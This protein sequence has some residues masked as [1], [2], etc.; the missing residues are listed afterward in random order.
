MIELTCGCLPDEAFPVGVGKINAKP[1]LD[2]C[3]GQRAKA[4]GKLGSPI[5]KRFKK[6][7]PKLPI[8]TA[9]G[10][11]PIYDIEIDPL[12]IAICSGT[13]GYGYGYGNQES[14]E[15]KDGQIKNEFL[16]FIVN[17]GSA[18]IE[19]R[20]GVDPTYHDDALG[21]EKLWMFPDSAERNAEKEFDLSYF[22]ASLDLPLE[23][24]TPKVIDSKL[25]ADGKVYAFAYLNPLGNDEIGVGET[26][27]QSCDEVSSKPDWA[28]SQDGS[29]ANQPVTPQVYIAIFRLTYVDG[30]EK[31]QIS[32]KIPTGF[33]DF[34]DG[35]NKIISGGLAISKDGLTVAVSNQEEDSIFENNG[36]IKIFR[37]NSVTDN[38]IRIDENGYDSTLSKVDNPKTY[39]RNYIGKFRSPELF[40]TKREDKELA[41]IGKPLFNITE[42]VEIA[43]ETGEEYEEI[44]CTNTELFSNTINADLGVYVARD[45]RREDSYILVTKDDEEDLGTLDTGALYPEAESKRFDGMK[46]PRSVYFLNFINDK[47][48]LRSEIDSKSKY[49]QKRTVTSNNKP[50]VLENAVFYRYE[51][52]DYALTDNGVSIIQVQDIPDQDYYLDKMAD[53]PTVSLIDQGK[54]V[55]AGSIQQKTYDAETNTMVDAEISDAKQL[56]SNSSSYVA[57]KENN[58]AVP[59]GSVGDGGASPYLWTNNT[60]VTE[61]A[62]NLSNIRTI[63]ST[64]RA[65]AAIKNDGSVVSW[66]DTEFGANNE[67]NRF[68]S[69]ESVASLH[70]RLNYFSAITTEGKVSTWG[71]I[72]RIMENTDF[73]SLKQD[74]VLNKDFINIDPSQPD[75]EDTNHRYLYLYDQDVA[76]YLNLIKDQDPNVTVSDKLKKFT[77]I[78]SNPYASVALREDGVAVAW[79]DT[80]H[81]ARPYRDVYE[82]QDDDNQTEV[83]MSR[84]EAIRNEENKNKIQADQ[85]PAFL[86][87]GSIIRIVLFNSLHPDLSIVENVWKIVESSSGLLTLEGLDGSIPDF[88]LDGINEGFSTKINSVLYVNLG[89]D[90]Q[91]NDVLS[92]INKVELNNIDSVVSNYY[93]FAAVKKDGTAI[94]W[95][96]KGYGGDHPDF[97][98]AEGET[99][100]SI[101]STVFAF[102]ALTSTGR[103]VAWGKQSHGG[104]IT[105]GTESSHGDTSL[106]DAENPVTEIYSARVGFMAVRKDKSVVVWGNDSLRYGVRQVGPLARGLYGKRDNYGLGF[107]IDMDEDG[108][109][110]LTGNKRKSF[111]NNSFT[112]SVRLYR[113]FPK[114][115]AYQLMGVKGTLFGSV[116]RNDG[117]VSFGRT[118]KINRDASKI[119]THGLSEETVVLPDGTVENQTKDSIFQHHVHTSIYENAVE[120]GED[121]N[122]LYIRGG[123]SKKNPGGTRIYNDTFLSQST[124]IILPDGHNPDLP[125]INGD[126]GLKINNYFSIDASGFNIAIATPS[127]GEFL[128][129]NTNNGE[130]NIYSAKRDDF[131]QPIIKGWDHQKR[132]TLTPYIE[133]DNLAEVSGVSD[134]W[135]YSNL[136]G[137]NL[138][139]SYE[140]N[141]L[142]VSS[143]DSINI[144]EYKETA[145]ETSDWT[146]VSKF[147]QYDEPTIPTF[148]NSSQTFKSPTRYLAAHMDSGGSYVSTTFISTEANENDHYS[149]SVYSI[150]YD[151]PFSRLD[152][153]NLSQSYLSHFSSTIQ[154]SGEYSQYLLTKDTSLFNENGTPKAYGK[155]QSIAIGDR[156]TTSTMTFAFWSDVSERSKADK[157]IRWGRYNVN[158]LCE[159]TNAGRDVQIQFS[160]TNSGYTKK[161]K[162][163]SIQTPQFEELFHFIVTYN[164]DSEYI[165][166]FIAGESYEKETLPSFLSDFSISTEKSYV[167][168]FSLNTAQKEQILDDVRVFSRVLSRN[169]IFKLANHRKIAYRTDTYYYDVNYAR[170]NKFNLEFV[171]S[172][173]LDIPIPQFC[174]T[175]NYVDDCGRIL[176]TECDLDAEVKFC[177]FTGRPRV[178]YVKTFGGAERPRNLTDISLSGVQRFLDNTT[179]TVREDQQSNFDVFDPDWGDEF[180]F[181]VGAN[182]TS[183][184]RRTEQFISGVSVFERCHASMDLS[185][186]PRINGVGEIISRKMNSDFGVRQVLSKEGEITSRWLDK[187]HGDFVDWNATDIL[188]PARDSG[189]NVFVTQDGLKTEL[190]KSID[191]GVFIGGDYSSAQGPISDDAV[192]YIQASAVNTEFEGTFGFYL[193]DAIT[194][195]YETRLRMRLSGPVKNFESEISPKF[196]FSNIALKNASGETVVK[197]EDF[198]F[199]GDS[200]QYEE[201]PGYTTYSLAPTF[202]SSRKYQ[203]QDGYPNIDSPSG[204]IIT[205]DVRSEDRG[206]PYKPSAFD[207]GWAMDN[208]FGV[209]DPEFSDFYSVSGYNPTLRISAIEVYNSGRLIPFREQ[210]VGCYMLGQETGKRFERIIKPKQ[211]LFNTFDTN[212]H[213]ALSGISNPSGW[214]WEDNSYTYTNEDCDGAE[215]LLQIINND[216]SGSWITSNHVYN[217]S[218]KL[219]LKFGLDPDDDYYLFDPGQFATA[220]GSMFSRWFDPIQKIY[221]KEEKEVEV[222]DSFFEFDSIVLRVLANKN[223]DARDYSLDI[224][225]YSDDCIMNSTPKVGG[226]LQNVSGEFVYNYDSSS[227]DEFYPQGTIPH[228]SGFSDV[229]DLGLSSEAI[230][231]KNQYF[232]SFKTNNDGGDHY[233]LSNYPVVSGTDFR[234]YEV[235]LK[236]YDDDVE[237]GRSRNYKL[238]SLLE[239]LYLDIYALPSGANI[240]G[241]ELAVR[242]KPCAGLELNTL[243]GVNRSI[244]DGRS[245]GSFYPVSMQS[246]DQIVNAG[247]GY[248]PLSLIENI[249]HAYTTP[250]TIKTNYAR[251]WRGLDGISLNPFD[252]RQFDYSFDKGRRLKRPLLGAW[253]DFSDVD[254][255]FPSTVTLNSNHALENKS[256]ILT[257]AGVNVSP[258]LYE[259]I[260]S[261]FRNQDMFTT[262]APGYSSNYRT[263]DWTALSNGSN[264]YTNDPLYGR[265]SDAYDRVVRFGNKTTATISDVNPASGAAF[266]FRFIPDVNVSGEGQDNFYD[267]STI[268]SLTQLELVNQTGVFIGYS[269]GYLFASGENISGDTASVI[270]TIPFSGYQYP[271]SVLVTYSEHLDNKLRLYT[272]HEGSGN[273]QHLRDTSTAIEL[274]NHDETFRVGFGGDSMSGLPML[275]AE[276]G[277]SHAVRTESDLI[278]VDVSGANIVNQNAVLNHKQ[279]TADQFFSN[280][281]QKFF[282]PN[283]SHEN[284]STMLWSYVDE[285]TSVSPSAEWYL[286][287]FRGCD[288]NWQ[289]DSINNQKLGKRSYTTE[290]DDHLTFYLSHDGTSYYANIDNDLPSTL[291]SGL[292]YHSQVEND[293]LRFY[294]SD[295]AHNFH[296]IKKR[297]S[298]NLPAGYDFA[299]SALVVDLIYEHHSSGDLVWDCKDE[300]GPKL[301][302]S[303]YTKNQEPYYQT[304]EPNWGLINRHYHYVNPSSCLEKFESKFTYDDY[305]DES[306]SWAVFP[307]ERRLSESTEKYFS[308]DVD[309]MFL[310]IDISYPSGS[311]FNSELDIHAIHVRAEDAFV[312]PVEDSGVL[313]MIASGA[314]IENNALDFYTFGVLGYSSGVPSGLMM[315]TDGHVPVEDSGILKIIMSGFN[316]S[317]SSLGLVTVNKRRHDSGGDD[318]GDDYWQGGDYEQF[319]VG[320][321]VKGLQ[322]LISGQT[323]PTIY[324]D[325]GSLKMLTEGIGMDSGQMPLFIYNDQFGLQSISQLNLSMFAA[326]SG[327]SGVRSELSLSLYNDAES[328]SQFGTLNSSFNLSTSGESRFQTLVN[329]FASM[330]LFTF[331]PAELPASA[332]MPLFLDATPEPIEKSGT[333]EMMVRNNGVTNYLPNIPGELNFNW[334]GESY[335]EGIDLEDEPYASLPANDEIRGVDLFGYGNCDSD[336]EDKAFDE[337]VISDGIVWRDRVCN[338]GGIFRATN[339][340]TNLDAGYEDEYYGIR[341]YAGLKGSR[342]YFVSMTI[343]T[344]D[345]TPISIPRE[346]EE[347]EYGI[348]GPGTVGDQDQQ[349][350]NFSGIK[351]IG[352]YPYLSGDYSITSEF[353]VE[354]GRQN[355]DRYGFSSSCHGDLIAVG[356]PYHKILD[357]GNQL[358]DDAGAVFLYRRNEEQ[359]GRKADWY[360]EE[361]LLMPEGTRRDYIQREYGALVTYPPNLTIG[362]KKWAIGQEGREFGYSIDVGASGEK[363]VVVVGAPGAKWTRTFPEVTVSGIPVLMTIFTDKFTYNKDK[364]LQIRST[365]SKY[366]LLYKYFSKPWGEDPDIWHPQLDIHLLICQVYNSDNIDDLPNVPDNRQN[367]GAAPYWFNHVYINNLKDAQREDDDLLTEGFNKVVGKF[368]QIF[369]HNDNIYSGI[370][371]IFGV[372]GD[373]TFST[374]NKQ[375]FLGILDKFVD[376]YEDY[377]YASGVEDMSQSTYTPSIGYVEKI[378]DDAFVWNEATVNLMNKTLSSGNLIKTGNL[379]FI[380]EGIGQEFARDDVGEF[381]LPPESGGRAFVFEKEF[382]EWNLVQEFISPFEEIES[383]DDSYDENL[384]FDQ[385][386]PVDRYGHAVGISENCE[387]IS[388]GSPFSAEACQIFERNDDAN[389]DM[390]KVL[391][392]WLVETN[393]PY[394]NP[395]QDSI[396]RF[397]ELISGSGTIAT[398]TQVYK[399]LSKKNKFLL[400]KN[401]NIKLYDKIFK[402]HYT[403]IA[404]T[405]SFGIITNEFAGTSR[406][407][408]STSVSED[409]K[410]VVFGA[411]TDSFNE[412]DDKNV[413]YG[414]V[415]GVNYPEN[416][417]WASYTNAGAVRVFESRSYHTHNKAVEFYKFGNLDRSFNKQNLVNQGDT[418]AYEK[419]GSYFAVDNIPFERT[420]FDEIEIP[421][422]AG[423]AFIITPE[424]DA[425]SDEIM[426]NIKS[427]LSL[428]DRTLVLVGNDPQWKQGGIYSKSNEIINKILKKLGCRM[429]ITSA[430]N[431]VESLEA[432]VNTSG[433]QNDKFNVTLAHLPQYMHESDA[434][435]ENMYASGVGDI[436]I[437]LSDL[438]LEDLK[439][440]SPCDPD[441]PELDRCIPPIEHMGDLRSEWFSECADKIEFYTNWAFHFD[442]ANPGQSCKFY[443]Q[444]VKPLVVKPDEEITPILTAAEYIPQ[445]DKI[446]PAQSGE[447]EECTT[448]LSGIIRKENTIG[449]TTYEFAENHI[450]ELIF[451]IKDSGNQAVGLYTSINRD[452][453][454]NPEKENGR[455]ALLQGVGTDYSGSSNRQKV[456]VSD[457]SP[458]VTEEKFEEEE[459]SKLY[460][461]ASQLPENSWSMGLRFGDQYDPRNEDQNIAFYNNLVMID[462]EN[463]ARIS[464]LGGWTGRTSFE[465]AFADSVIKTGLENYNHIVDTN[466]IYKEDSIIPESVSVIWIA[467]PT[468]AIPENYVAPIKN[469]IKL[470]NKKVIVTYNRD[471]QIAT[472]V[473]LTLERLG[474]ETRPFFL[475]NQ[476]KYFIQDSRVLQDSAL[477]SCC[478]IDS[479]LSDKL[480]IINKE[481]DVIKG[482]SRGYKWFG[483]DPNNTKS[484]E[485]DK[486]SAIPNTANPQSLDDDGTDP[487]GDGYNGYAYIP[488]QISGSRTTKVV[489]MN[490]PIHDLVWSNPDTFWKID[491]DATISLPVTPESGYRLFVDWISETDNEIYDI[492]FQVDSEDVRFSADPEGDEFSEDS[493]KQLGK[494]TKFISK[495][496]SV[497]FRVKSGVEN[498]RVKLDTKKWRAIKDEDVKGDRPYTPRILQVR[499]YPL[500]IIETYNETTTFKDEK[501]YITKCSGVPWYIPERRITFPPIFRPVSTNHVKYCNPDAELCSEYDPTLDVEDGPVI[502]ADELEHFSDFSTGSKRSRVV[503]VTDSSM[504][505]G[506]NEHYRY[507]IT[508]PNVRFIRSLYPQRPSESFFYSEDDQYISKKGTKFEFTQKLRAPEKGSPSKYFASSGNQYLVEKFGLNGVAG[509]LENYTDQ[510][511]NF[512]LGDVFR[513]FTP[514]EPVKIEQEIERFGGEVVPVY[515]TYPRFSGNF[516]DPEVGEVNHWVDSNINGGVSKYMERT[517]RDYLDYEVLSSG[518][519]G[520]LFGFSVDLY[521]GK[522]VIGTPFNAYHSEQAISW[523]GIYDAYTAGNVGSGLNLS[524]RGGAGAAFYFERTGRGENAIKEFLPWEYKQKIKPVDSLNVGIDDATASD[525]TTLKGSH[526]FS[527]EFADAFAWVPDLFGW[528]VS[529]ESDFIAVGAPAHDYETLHNHIYSGQ[530]AFLRKEFSY[531]FDIPT[532]E[533]YDLGDA[534]VRGQYP[535][536]GEMILNNGAV[537]TFRHDFDNY[538]DRN[539]VWNF[540]EKIVAQGHNDRLAGSPP[541][542]GAENDMFGYSVCLQQAKRSDSDYVMIVGAPY[543]MHPTSGNHISIEISGAG[544]AYTYDAMLRHQPNVVPTQGS[545]IIPTV[546]GDTVGPNR[547]GSVSGKFYQNVEGPEITYRISGVISATP[548][549]SIFLEVS[550]YDPADRGFTSQRPF[551]ESIYGEYLS[552][553]EVDQNIFMLTAGKAPEAS[554]V[555]PLFVYNNDEEIVSSSMYA[556]MY[557]GEPIVIDNSFG[558]VTSGIGNI[559]KS[560][561]FRTRGK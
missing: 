232:D 129:N 200:D 493:P 267:Q 34:S 157:I 424:L 508:S 509:N 498:I 28:V 310:Q 375:S 12:N 136:F 300:V 410:T 415:T 103:V 254:D 171:E 402:Y 101:S 66:G 501:V 306:E 84:P 516:Y 122:K 522:L 269:G 344:G 252:I 140:G 468:E 425:A 514:R 177:F 70:P 35:A 548:Q 476:A 462:C 120:L 166:L 488:I 291:N 370:P 270:D 340:Y 153:D 142:L 24:Q 464:Q 16:D 64:Q 30:K 82:F 80:M 125:Y 328:F 456:K 208:D 499:G 461:I 89:L 52:L 399:E 53:D 259:N 525:L 314:F 439:V 330:P 91:E 39:Q 510:E 551:I 426:D 496:H 528:S 320:N 466:V 191:E 229:D 244:Q 199:V 361:K 155:N 289:Y 95:G 411:P 349:T 248:Q 108:E 3:N 201:D 539:K 347:W 485:V 553:T 65:H 414:G 154:K 25:S 90:R 7:L 495:S 11:G 5:R 72:N 62:V 237:L 542:S 446:I 260:G 40:F 14:C 368:K 212:I 304:D 559:Q 32:N 396:D 545:Y 322:M 507:D 97:A 227:L 152:Y 316:V 221:N 460:L 511:D 98:L 167:G 492:N 469:W 110:I 165:E 467:S 437:D 286:G 451:N 258:E 100:V 164:R 506:F 292:A 345:T 194:S 174:N 189:N 250:S 216:S 172:T 450:N 362:A 336:S 71:N 233:A 242:H 371:P 205:F 448:T 278:G 419:L 266:F 131:I 301:I 459:T 104:D 403:D 239:K 550:G 343:K 31:W 79:G 379:K 27:P 503:L 192:T 273:F 544:S 313:K 115:A 519:N 276:F 263:A 290:R 470:G 176:D 401:K 186:R 262:L 505:Q 307:K 146:Q 196:Y 85:V 445:A 541:V 161:F 302:V 479:E 491:G 377:S 356:A 228:T 530:A 271:L 94:S 203:W 9:V 490:D 170:G 179:P 217:D 280:I 222:Q 168:G 487:E 181:V 381:Q 143:R 405:G 193:T 264:D 247:S 359:A 218:G 58:V 26:P 180:M 219:I 215:Q 139:L 395:L 204:Y 230:S 317:N 241:I 319:I 515:G 430:R 471:Q 158:I 309:D 56:F 385:R 117:R 400:R 159:P 312:K 338:E 346:W 150:D 418:N 449:T 183:P 185:P 10:E 37:Y 112:G 465:D 297:V 88:N 524:G 329:S 341:K 54:V 393:D 383:N 279:I 128:S 512:V 352:D 245:E 534:D 409:G 226:F 357:S 537:Y 234:W 133:E 397:N 173:Y 220:F 160:D 151:S 55:T 453:F 435:R 162:K 489:T 114:T 198:N 318:D 138:S 416:N 353:Q 366:D 486:L 102:A 182:H 246:N 1:N 433:I 2:M 305:C 130:V 367:R 447:E 431:R 206:E 358:I 46:R 285:N 111:F 145:Y 277:F 19:Y 386:N 455:D 382:G 59:Y 195:P 374:N 118:V 552:G 454:V 387:I 50:T 517:G 443:P 137:E 261:R 288:F 294:L 77:S 293:F 427:W 33:F 520:D 76:A 560:L 311:A 432:G 373:D 283:E 538:Q 175:I 8:K 296:S 378:F 134:N 295:T 529:V 331:A 355:G 360:L 323:P 554:A 224:V 124:Q 23:R 113:R 106:S 284:D 372:F 207:F 531:E 558:F 497:D 303:L 253:I 363:E 543:H 480:Q 105:F 342:P 255:G 15:F 412:F 299:D 202:N 188:Y 549:G 60:K 413:W 533:F 282:D 494:T 482:C 149:H 210:F 391:Y 404:Y 184:A 197:Y 83:D 332:S 178:T 502:V 45:Q 532:H 398:A 18:E 392:D 63:S 556:Y 394:E 483:M 521:K 223:A 337:Q 144:Y 236:V 546:Y 74:N 388:V 390:Y 350:L 457:I 417:T 96:L 22:I 49:I 41:V 147:Y 354:S 442:T 315:Y 540:A 238:S 42:S 6:C 51:T 351:L 44:A 21:G 17:Y 484:T 73:E 473:D 376:F 389:T 119:F 209:N 75:R 463:R 20:I 281:R 86:T 268:A 423:L 132:L 47:N 135:T 428:G 141:R 429:R 123:F 339:T 384:L 325:S 57:L 500:E 333:L 116:L 298:K 257:E 536:S 272:D 436:R 163:L 36:R 547:L 243:G 256:A 527:D 126:Y 190:Y 513:R 29:F 225:G 61:D 109:A 275:L 438:E 518:Y 287:A 214:L 458:Y 265:I 324:E 274:E 365:A 441:N 348:C 48:S 327:A 504:I 81:G 67:E 13:Y 69:I 369:P 87:A 561:I 169:E 68:G 474:M 472:N 156:S 408:F 444:I 127:S 420:D 422:D 407:G 99:I 421:K 92:F 555:M 481:N 523:S 308:K 38:Y 211:F 4:R 477:S 235:K 475:Q 380:T 249:P 335:G 321:G 334:D 526:N 148:F 240:A 213:P 535:G 121:F 43:L 434:L 478:P 78:V 231:D 440:Y 93:A 557:D 452:K 107:S 406:L 326:T 364:L 251:R 187:F